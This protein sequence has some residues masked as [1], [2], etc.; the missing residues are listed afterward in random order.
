MTAAFS[1]S[2]QQHAV[3]KAIRRDPGVT[4]GMLADEW[5]IGR[6]TLQRWIRESRA[7]MPKSTELDRD[8]VLSSIVQPLH[9]RSFHWRMHPAF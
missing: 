1:I 7:T 2:F 9:C 6:S 8:L 4:L 3:E 5:G